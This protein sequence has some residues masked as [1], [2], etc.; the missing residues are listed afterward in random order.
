MKRIIAVIKGS[1]GWVW[2]KTSA[3]YA[4]AAKLVKA[5]KSFLLALAVTVLG[6]VI[7]D[8]V[9]RIIFSAPLM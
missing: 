2:S 9:I 3:I 7:A 8:V 5:S 4:L 6:T 1:M